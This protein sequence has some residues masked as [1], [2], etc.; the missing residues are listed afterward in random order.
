MRYTR[1][2]RHAYMEGVL[3]ICA[4][5]MLVG[6]LSM[7]MSCASAT[8]PTTLS[9]VADTGTKIVQTAHQISLSAQSLQASGVLTVPQAAIVVEG[10]FQIEQD[11]EKLATDLTAY[12]AAVGTLQAPLTAAS[13]QA[14]IADMDT[15]LASVGKSI[16]SGTASAITN[17]VAS[18]LALIGQIKAGLLLAGA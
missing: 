11:G 3:S 7:W 13:I 5:A 2:Y 17:G 4:G 9:Q 10:A 14:L 1:R 8:Y 18:I 6:F 12:R 15:V 16:P